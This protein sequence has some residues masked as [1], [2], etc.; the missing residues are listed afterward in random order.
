DPVSSLDHMHRENLAKRLVNKAEERQVIIFTHDI[1]F[2]HFL[3]EFCRTKQ[4][5]IKYQHITKRPNSTETGICHDSL[6][7]K[8][9][10]ISKRL[11]KLTNR[12]S[13]KKRFYEVNDESEWHEAVRG[14]QTDIRLVWERSVEAFVSDVLTRFSTK[15]NTQNLFKLTALELKDCKDMRDAFTRCSKWSH[16]QGVGYELK[17]PNPDE[18]LKEI[19]ALENWNN[20]IKNRKE[21]VEKIA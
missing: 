21:S 18:V 6:P 9:Q 16:D 11:E 7:P 15:V 20:D 4:V 12:L 8:A 3:G 5:K 2:L 14:F 1:H 19:K 13:N 10:D 17:I